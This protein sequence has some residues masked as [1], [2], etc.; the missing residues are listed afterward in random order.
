MITGHARRHRRG[1]H[2]Q[3]AGLRLWRPYASSDERGRAFV[4]RTID[5]AGR[6]RG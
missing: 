5:S 2:P 6:F 1:R 4:Q 3:Q